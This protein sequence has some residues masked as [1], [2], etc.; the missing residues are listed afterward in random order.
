M[1][2]S[3]TCVMS[4]VNNAKTSRNVEIARAVLCGE[5]MRAVAARHGITHHRVHIIAHRVLQQADPELYH[6]CSEYYY[7][8]KGRHVANMDKLRQY[9]RALLRKL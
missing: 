8:G 2:R 9:K 5:N 7:R 3:A 1:P 4:C 6:K